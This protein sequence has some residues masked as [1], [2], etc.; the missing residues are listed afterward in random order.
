[1]N[2]YSYKNQ[3]PSPL[4]FR[5]I[6]D[7]GETRTSLS[8]LSSEEL[9]ELGFDGPITV[10]TFNEET[11]KLSWNGTEYLVVDYTQEELD[12]IAGMKESIAV[13]EKRQNL[14]YVLFWNELI[15]TN[16]YKRIR[17]SASQSLSANTICTEIISIFC[18]AKSGNP[19]EG[20]IQKYISILFLVFDPTLDE[21]EELKLCMNNSN[22]STVFNLPDEQYLQKHTYNEAENMI[23]I[24]LI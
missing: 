4:P 1:M 21:V 7:S 13:N 24:D 19:N 14:N 9:N 17:I 12:L 20:E 5:V 16:L 11:Q 8:E 6:L 10:P 3:E 2:L 22:L 18:D 15:K 23:L